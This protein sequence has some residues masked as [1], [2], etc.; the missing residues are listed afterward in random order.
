ML[1]SSLSFLYYYLPIL[2]ISYLVLH[3]C[4]VRIPWK[5]ALLLGFSILFYAWGEPRYVLLVF[6]Q[7]ILSYSAGIIIERYRTKVLAKWALVLSLL[8]IIGALLY[9]KYADFFLANFAAATGLSISLLRIALP[10][11]ISFYTFEIISY[12]V[13]L[14]KGHIKTQ[15]NIITYATYILLFPKLIAGP[16]V[17]YYEIETDLIN[18][19]V[20]MPKFASGVRRFIIGLGKKILLAN[21]MAQL[22]SIIK[23][24]PEHSILFAW[25]YVIA[26]ALQIYFDFSGYT[27]MALG[28]GSMFGFT[29]PE[30]FNYPYMSKSIT[31]FWRRW[32][33][34]LS[35]WFRDYVYIPLGGNRKWQIRNIL[36]VWL[37]TGFW[38]GAAWNFI[39]WGFF[40]AVFL[41]IEK[42]FLKV[43]L[44]R[45]HKII[46]HGYLIL[47][48]LIS[49]VFF[50]AISLGEAFATIGRLFGVGVSGGGGR[51]S[52]YYLRSY[53]L[54]L[55]FAMFGATNVPKQ[56]YQCLNEKY[57]TWMTIIEPVGL[58]LMLVV[59]TAFL[60]DGSFNP[61]IYFRF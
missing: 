57:K 55:G 23:D 24:S 52:L 12:I 13:D 2:L 18:R 44:E 1:F 33:M 6:G 29:F 42:Y 46:Q 8:A 30:N 11:G 15:H 39:G 53:M 60:V 45:S 48:I 58:V 3:V 43:L 17:R 9:F 22:V 32:H 34:T 28:L 14:Y 26:F 56:I 51:E 59:I 21:V 5:N 19:T 54:P 41:L 47:I 35:F 37:L 38:H 27:D 40:F 10:V 31:E 7:I 61:F 16:I 20:S 50:D 49:W 25:M 36:I 4:K